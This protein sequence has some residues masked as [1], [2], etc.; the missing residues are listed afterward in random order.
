LPRWLDGAGNLVG[1]GD[2]VVSPAAS[3]VYTAVISDSCGNTLVETVGIAVRPELSVASL[4]D[5]TICQGES[6]TYTAVA[7]GSGTLNYTWTGSG[8]FVGP[9]S[10]AV[11]LT[12]SATQTYTLAVADECSSRT[13]TF[14]VNVHPA[15]LAI[16]DFAAPA[17]VC[18]GTQ[19]DLNPTVSGG[20]GNYVYA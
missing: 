20:T 2:V 9:N 14:T 8:G 1:F 15:T 16:S 13:T 19:V 12:P 10:A 7:S 5:R 3:T 6:A 18:A 4:D 11:T 17:A